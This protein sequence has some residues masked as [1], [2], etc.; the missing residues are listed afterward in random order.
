M[1]ETPVYYYRH[2]VSKNPNSLIARRIFIESLIDCNLIDEAQKEINQAKNIFLENQILFDVYQCKIDHIIGDR[3]SSVNKLVE[4][5]KHNFKYHELL[6]IAEILAS[7]GSFEKALVV[8]EKAHKSQTIGNRKI[9]SLLAQIHIKRLLKEPDDTLIL[10]KEI[11]D[12]F[13]D[14]YQEIDGDE[15]TAI[16]E[17]QL[18]IAST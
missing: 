12:I 4:Y 6:N 16:R 11:Y 10:F 5:S 15:I 13:K 9:D 14:D 7:I 8:Y 1:E 18:T 17:L 2:Y 3:E